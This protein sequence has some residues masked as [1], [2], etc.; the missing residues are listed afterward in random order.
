[1]KLAHRNAIV[2]GGSQGLGRAIV[3]TFVREGANVLFCARDEQAAAAAGRIASRPTR[4]L[5]GQRVIAQGCDVSS[6]EDVEQLFAVGDAM[7]DTLHILVNNAGIYG[8]MG[9]TDEVDFE[10]WRRAW[11]STCT[12]RSCPA[13]R[14]CAGSKR[15]VTARSST[16]PAAAR[17]IPCPTS[18]PM[19]PAR[20]PSCA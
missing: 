9:P 5:P 6:P 12:A 4:P 1:M 15:A 14:P 18:A 16:F 11:T 2:T 7:F 10:E 13:A 20:P 19:P 8:P 3:E 17:P